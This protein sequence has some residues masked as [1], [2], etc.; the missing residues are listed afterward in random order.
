MAGPGANDGKRSA[1]EVLLELLDLV[2]DASQLDRLLEPANL[3]H[4]L[5]ARGRSKD[6]IRAA[7]AV[8]LPGELL[9]E[10]LRS[11][12]TAPELLALCAPAPR[13]VPAHGGGA[14]ATSL[15]PYAPPIEPDRAEP[16]YPPTTPFQETTTLH[17][18]AAWGFVISVLVPALILGGV[19]SEWSVLTPAV[20]IAIATG[21]AA[22]S[23][24]LFVHRRAPHHVGVIG[25]V[26]CAPGALLAIT[27]W[28]HGRTSVWRLEI[29]IAFLIGALPGALVYMWLFNRAVRAAPARDD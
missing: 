25:G 17:K 26:L 23:G 5:T 27:F 20:W 28:T 6:E 4:I 29:A 10:V 16:R 12:A 19:F 13:E 3:L 18:V 7:L 11:G 21:G 22:L 9:L 1:G 15:D 24:A 8:K 2:P 14:R